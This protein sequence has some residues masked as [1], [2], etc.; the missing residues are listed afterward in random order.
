MPKQSTETPMLKPPELPFL[1]RFSV[2]DRGGEEL[3]WAGTFARVV[4]QRMQNK[5][6]TGHVYNEWATTVAVDDNERLIELNQSDQLEL[7]KQLDVGIKEF[8]YFTNATYS[9]DQI[10]S[11][12][13]DGELAQGFNVAAKTMLQKIISKQRQVL[14]DPR[15]ASEQA[16]RYNYA[17]RD[18]TF[19]LTNISSALNLSGAWDD[20]L[21]NINIWYSRGRK[22]RNSGYIAE[23][24]VCN[25]EFDPDDIDHSAQVDELDPDDLWPDEFYYPG[26]LEV[27][28]DP[29]RR[30]EF[31]YT[32]ELE[33]AQNRH[34]SHATTV[35][36]GV[37][38]IYSNN[39]LSI[40]IDLDSTAPC[41][42]ALDI[43]RSTYEGEKDGRSLHRD[44]DLL[45]S[46][47][48]EIGDQGSHEYTGFAEGVSQEFKNFAERLA[49]QLNLQN[50]EIQKAK[51]SR[52]VL[53]KVA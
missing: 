45:G 25:D 34:V 49:I 51:L 47:F 20:D 8:D 41:G 39:A 50:K 9:I 33:S 12:L 30:I 27:R 36:G 17:L 16:D 18:L 21:L 6:Y 11:S 19:A 13:P 7:F 44:S 48:D 29:E 22:S 28:V 23:Y 5:D 38:R 10:S 31:V 53:S 40:R 4:S 37:E 26:K 46:V 2:I 3:V 32:P 14:L 15:T 52:A 35:Q 24:I 43:G 42:V 1:P